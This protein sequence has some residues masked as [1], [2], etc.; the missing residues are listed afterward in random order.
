VILLEASW[1]ELPE[2]G[3]RRFELQ[4]AQIVVRVDGKEVGAEFWDLALHL[5][6]P[7]EGK[8]RAAILI[9]RTRALVVELP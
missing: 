7:R 8:G 5:P 6:R 4:P 3:R 1:R 9:A 2:D